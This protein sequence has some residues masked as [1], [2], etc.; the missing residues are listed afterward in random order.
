MKKAI[1][2]TRPVNWSA[3]YLKVLRDIRDSF[4]NTRNPPASTLLHVND[5]FR[6]DVLPEVDATAIIP[7]SQTYLPAKQLQT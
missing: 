5:F 6:E 7:K 3:A 2:L 4:V 1:H